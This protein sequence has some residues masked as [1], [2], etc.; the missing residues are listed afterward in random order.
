MLALENLL[1]EDTQNVQLKANYAAARKHY[2]V[3][4][5]RAISTG[6]LQNG[7]SAEEIAEA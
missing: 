7:I 4:K 2:A 6:P 1:A 5:Q 3:T